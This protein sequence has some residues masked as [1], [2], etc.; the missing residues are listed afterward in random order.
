M[1]SPRARAPP[2]DWLLLFSVAAP[3]RCASSRGQEAP[4]SEASTVPMGGKDNAAGR[5]LSALSAHLAKPVVVAADAAG[6]GVAAAPASAAS[7]AECH[8]PAAGHLVIVGG[9][10]SADS[11]IVAKFIELGGGAGTARVVII[12]TASLPTDGSGDVAKASAK[13]VSMFESNGAASVDV[14]H[15]VDRELADTDEF[16]APIH[17]ASVVFFGGGRQWKIFD[18]YSGTQVQTEVDALL[19]R[20]G[21]VGG[22][23]AGASILGE[24]MARGDTAT[25]FTMLGDHQVGFGL[26]SGASID[27]HFL[28]RAFSHTTAKGF[29]AD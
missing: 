13:M 29:A 24:H 27:Q 21:V 3:R 17:D 10:M 28:A 12:P 19:A 26:L 23:S 25:N 20:G 18:A 5:R 9:A 2:P 22:S 7:A 8:G 4:Y 14:L 16:A 1:S 11:G 15:T 6:A